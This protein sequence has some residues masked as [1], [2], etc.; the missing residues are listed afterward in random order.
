MFEC[1]KSLDNSEIRLSADSTCDKFKC[2]KSFLATG[3]QDA[4]ELERQIYIYTHK[5]L[6]HMNMLNVFTLENQMDGV[7]SM[8]ICRQIETMNHSDCSG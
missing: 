3:I 1:A 8:H 5:Y 7:T 4:R 6:S 2:S